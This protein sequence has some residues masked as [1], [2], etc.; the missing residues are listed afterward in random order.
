[1]KGQVV[2]SEGDLA[3]TTF[4]EYKQLSDTATLTME[5]GDGKNPQSS[6]QDREERGIWVA[7]LVGHLIL[8]FGS[9]S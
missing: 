8:D 3:Q 1:M 6:H 5:G 7:Q 9:R 4:A 2:E